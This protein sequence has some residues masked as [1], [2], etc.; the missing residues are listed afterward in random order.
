M[1]AASHLSDAEDVLL[2]SVGGGGETPNFSRNDRLLDFGE[3]HDDRLLAALYSASDLFLIP[4]LEDNLP[5]TVIEAMACG[6]PVVGFNVGG[7]PDMVRS[8]ETGLLVDAGDA[9]A[10]SGA[11][12]RLLS[13][14]QTLAHMGR[15]SRG[16][17]V[18]EFSLEGQARRFIKLYGELTASG[19][20][21]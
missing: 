4:S 16:V 19:S 15:Q 21:S 11:V 1:S 13:E 7:I 18:E 10:L 9:S 3:V 12:R 5:N 17:A 8:G 2:V 14:P 6:T 20:G